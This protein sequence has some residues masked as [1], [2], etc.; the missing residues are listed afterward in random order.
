M[1]NTTNT[2]VSK[3]MSKV[4]TYLP[5][6]HTHTH[7]HP[8]LPI[9]TPPSFTHAH[10]KHADS[11]E[12]VTQVLCIIAHVCRDMIGNPD[13]SKRCDSPLCSSLS[14]LSYVSDL[15][16]REPWSCASGSWSVPLPSTTPSILSGR[17]HARIP[18]SMY[19]EF[20]YGFSFLH[21]CSVVPAVSIAS[22]LNSGCWVRACSPQS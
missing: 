6:T 10:T 5:H 11:A 13:L 7:T 18:K 20:N 21:S 1:L 4:S 9:I 2:V 17:I 19:D 14:Q 15:S 8:S 16:N 12:R 3:Y 22:V